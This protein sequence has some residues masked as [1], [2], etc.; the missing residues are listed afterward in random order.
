MLG[1]GKR[2]GNQNVMGQGCRGS[3]NGQ[4]RVR[5]DLFS[6]LSEGRVDCG[7]G[8]LF[9]GAKVTTVLYKGLSTASWVSPGH[10]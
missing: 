6:N 9:T 2:L 4:V 8:E 5:V 7:L 3:G 10:E 1:Q